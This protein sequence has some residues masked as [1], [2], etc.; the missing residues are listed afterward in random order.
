MC[1]HK[2]V[3]CAECATVT[4]SAK[5]LSD[6]IS[7]ILVT[8]EFDEVKNSWIAIALVDGSTDYTLYPSRESAIKHQANE[9]H[10]TYLSLRNCP[11]GM[12][13]KDAQLWLDV[14]RHAYD[15]GLRLADPDSPDMIFPQ[16]K[17]SHITKPVFPV[18]DPIAAFRRR[19]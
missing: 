15:K 2:R 18:L 8:H 19:K 6:A 1:K 10:F 12:S 13:K 7:L 4:D 16:A 11:A 9:F 14:H 17:E 5:R 3:I